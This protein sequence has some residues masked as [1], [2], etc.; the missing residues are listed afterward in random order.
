MRFNDYKCIYK[1]RDGEVAIMFKERNSI[2]N[3][4]L[5]FNDD[6]KKFKDRILG[7]NLNNRLNLI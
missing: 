3:L 6:D 7:I 5:D 4:D 2:F 1:N